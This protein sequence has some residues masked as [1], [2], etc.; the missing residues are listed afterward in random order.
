MVETST[1]MNNNNGGGGLSQDYFDETVLENEDVFDM[2]PEEAVTETIFQLY[3][4]QQ[5]QQQ[6]YQQPGCDGR[7]QWWTAKF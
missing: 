2:S 7:L 5:Q 4:Q 6:Q 3:Q 1:T